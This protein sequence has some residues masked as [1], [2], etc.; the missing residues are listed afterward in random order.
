MALTTNKTGGGQFEPGQQHLY[1]TAVRP[2]EQQS[3][4]NEQLMIKTGGNAFEPG[5]K[6]AYFI[7]SNVDRMRFGVAGHSHLL[8]A[9]NELKGGKELAHL[10]EWLN[11]G[12]KVFIDSGIF[13]LT[14]EHKRKHGITMDQALALPPD[15]IDGFDKLLARYVEIVTRYESRVWGYIELDQGGREQK[16]KTRTMLEGMGLR[17][18]PVYHPFNDGWDYFDYLAERYDR[19][20]FGNVV[21]AN[22]ETRLRLVATAWER[23]RKYPHLWIHLLGLTPNQWLYALPISSGDSSSWLSSVR[24]SGHNPQAMGM[25]LGGMPRDFQYKLGSDA[26]GDRGSRKA[27]LMSAIEANCTMKNWQHYLREMEAKGF[28]VYATI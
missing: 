12:K 19:I 13:N 28:D 1:F 3:Y 10:D 24:F 7:A 15:Q 2:G 23:H 14:N 20:C 27:V 18:I 11:D 22:K 21:Q 25:P 26:N 17:P 6:G 8:I 4:S 5:E 9:V 16:I